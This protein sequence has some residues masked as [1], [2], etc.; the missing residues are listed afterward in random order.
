MKF[1]KNIALAL[2]ATAA[3]TGAVM[4]AGAA[5]HPIQQKWSF[6]GAFGKY[7][8]ASAQRGWQVYKQV[9]SACHSLKYFRFRNLAELGYS[10]DMIKAFAAEY[11][12]A[13]EPDDAGDETV[14]NALPQDAFPAP[15]ANENAARAS[16]GGALPPDL[17]LLAKARHD[18]SNYLFS[19]LT[20]YEDAPAGFELSAG[21][22]YNPYFKGGQISMAPPLAE[23]IVEYEDGTAATPEQMARDV[24]M[25]LTYVAEPKLED[26]HRMGMNVLI[27]LGILSIILYLSMKKIW[28]PV[29]EGKNFYDD[30]E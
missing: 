8:R 29:K 6:D 2:T 18:G 14:R 1:F 5:K 24:T 25:F 17:S 4:A 3:L 10:E 19:I 7:D 20:G 28:K 13:G 21:K 16:N 12:V 23:G 15:F 27:F 22:N 11:E 30:A 26:R 9:C